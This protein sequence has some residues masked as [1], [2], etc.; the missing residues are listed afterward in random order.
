[1]KNGYAKQMFPDLFKEQEE[2]KWITISE[3]K[4]PI[5]PSWWSESFIEMEQNELDNMVRLAKVLLMGLN[6]GVPREVAEK[7]VNDIF[8]HKLNPPMHE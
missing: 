5:M 6:G 4:G 3:V 2:P 1:M 8:H 7:A